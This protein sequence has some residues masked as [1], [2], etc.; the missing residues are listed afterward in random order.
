MFFGCLPCCDK[1]CGFESA[2]LGLDFVGSL[3]YAYAGVRGSFSV[4]VGSP[5]D[6]HIISGSIQFNTTVSSAITAQGNSS[7]WRALLYENVV[8]F[9]AVGTAGQDDFAERLYLYVRDNFIEAS[10][11]S[12]RA[13]HIILSHVW[14]R[15]TFSTNV[16]TANFVGVG[17]GS[18]NF[19]R[20]TPCGGLDGSTEY[21]EHF[22]SHSVGTV[23]AINEMSFAGT[24][25]SQSFN[26]SNLALWQLT[27]SFDRANGSA[28]AFPLN[29][30][31]DLEIEQL[32]SVGTPRL[33]RHY[34]NI[35]ISRA[36]FVVNDGAGT[37][38]TA[39]RVSVIPYGLTNIL[40]Y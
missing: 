38:S 16:P 25:V 27:A 28:S 29:I 34:C 1:Y 20:H 24:A 12:D 35:N 19:L 33:S 7:T 39:P 2:V 18:Y 37:L 4:P 9:S 40:Y 26:F 31:T 23:T 3:D 21:I 22:A 5:A 6:E 10:P 15:E 13:L 11:L 17:I 36:E 14:E 8:T 32:V 30:K